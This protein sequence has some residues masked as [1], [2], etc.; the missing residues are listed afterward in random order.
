VTEPR[1]P[2][3]RSISVSKLVPG[4]IAVAAVIAIGAA[5][6]VGRVVL[7]VSGA[8]FLVV[9]T[10]LGYWAWRSRQAP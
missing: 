4:I 9:A 3:N 2:L 8:V 1:S 6:A 7:A 5:I 10:V